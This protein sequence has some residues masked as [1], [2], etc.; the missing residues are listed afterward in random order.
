MG[1]LSKSNPQQ[2]K[3]TTGVKIQFVAKFIFSEYGSLNVLNG[4]VLQS[5]HPS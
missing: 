2:A 3:A 1:L 4:V 5:S